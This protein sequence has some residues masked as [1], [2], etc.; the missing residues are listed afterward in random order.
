MAKEMASETPEET[1]ARRVQDRVALMYLHV[2]SKMM[3]FHSKLS[4]LQTPISRYTC[5]NVKG[6]NEYAHMTDMT[7]NH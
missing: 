3:Q 5:M 4:A 1:E 2:H 6:E 7:L